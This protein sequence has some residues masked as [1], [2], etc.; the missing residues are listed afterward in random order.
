MSIRH[1]IVATASG[2]FYDG[3]DQEF[4]KREKTLLSEDGRL[5]C[6]S[7]GENGSKRKLFMELVLPFY[8]SFSSIHSQE[9]HF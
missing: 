4:S 5:E 6:I 9:F 8:T 1:D 7:R 2:N 3:R